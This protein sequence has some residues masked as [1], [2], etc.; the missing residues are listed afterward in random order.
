MIVDAARYLDGHRLSEAPSQDV[1]DLRALRAGCRD[2]E[3]AWVGLHDPQEDELAEVARVFELHPLSVEDAR[4]AHQR[5]KLERY[6]Q[7]LFLVLKTLWYVDAEDAVETGEIDVFIGP[8]FVVTVRHGAGA[9]LDGA[10]SALESHEE[11]LRHGTA[12]VLH[13]VCDRVVEEY[14]RVAGELMVDVDEVEASV[15]SDERT[16]DSARIYVLKR[17]LAEMR[18]AVMPLREPLRRLASG[19]VEGVESKAAPYFRD[20]AD[21]LDLVAEDVESLDGLLSTAFD[22]HATRISMQ[23]NDDMR[24][25]SAGA[26]LV[27]VPTLIAGV[28]GMNFEHMPELAW[29]FGYAYALLLMGGTAA[30]LWWLF[31]RSGWL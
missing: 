2:G 11:L 15:F 28:Y 18:R 29:R 3:V 19:E 1:A 12:A 8:D 26:A 14:G 9:P 13:A 25:I 4:D 30:G 27:V 23:Q 7:T 21:H 31:K 16:Q 5:P 17:E 6:G 22:A 24:K 10:R 20:I